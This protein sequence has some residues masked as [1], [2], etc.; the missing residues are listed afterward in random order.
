MKRWVAPLAA[1]VL[2]AA[3]TFVA[4]DGL[5]DDDIRGSRQTSTVA[6]PDGSAG[7][8]V[9][10][11]MGCGGCHQLSTAG[12]GGGPGPNLDDRLSAHTRASLVAKITDPYPRQPGEQQ[13]VGGMPDDYAERMSGKELNALVDFLL[14][15][16]GGR[17]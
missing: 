4:V 5:G 7:R 3:A 10:A 9:F 12:S 2:A 16:R 15:A 13:F 17:P 14:T 8:A 6:Q 1:G 11:R